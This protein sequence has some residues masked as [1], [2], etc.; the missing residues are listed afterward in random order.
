MKIDRIRVL[1]V[2]AAIGCVLLFL[3]FLAAVDVEPFGSARWFVFVGIDLVGIAV[4]GV[5]WVNRR[6]DEARIRWVFAPLGCLIFVVVA[7][8]LLV[9]SLKIR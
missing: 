8:V 9:I 5:F 6:P 3:A 1:T 7:S 2:V 4:V